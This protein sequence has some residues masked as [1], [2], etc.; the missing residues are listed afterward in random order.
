MAAD[1]ISNVAKNTTAET[2]SPNLDIQ[3]LLFYAGR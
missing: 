2:N 3:S 1:C